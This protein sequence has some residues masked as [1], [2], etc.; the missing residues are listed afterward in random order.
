MSKLSK[1]ILNTTNEMLEFLVKLPSVPCGLP[2]EEKLADDLGV[3]R[4][5][6]RKVVDL[7]SEKGIVLKDGSNKM[8]LRRPVKND[9][10]TSKELDNS[11][12]DKIEKL[13][14]K[15]LSTY[16]LKPKDR[17]AE[18]ELAKAFDCNTVTVREVLL[19][20][21]QTG[22][23][24]K[25]P[26]QKWEVVSLTMDM[27]EEVVS[28]RKL[29]E[30]YALSKFQN[31]S[32]EDVIWQQLEKL[33]SN[34]LQILLEKN[35]SIHALAEIERAFHY[36]LL[37]ACGNRYIEKSYNSLF[38]LITYHLWQIEYD[39]TKIER[40]IKQHLEIINNLLNRQFDKAKALLQYHIEDAK[41]SMTDLVFS[42]NAH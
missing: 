26:R 17:F 30:G 19:K 25:S 32:D 16:E 20:I 2:P 13:I 22:I 38:T 39:H 37:R 1:L 6:I 14:L 28:A 34:H 42:K 7:L 11:K 24:K 15:K 23:I 10:Y 8:V 41:A 27:I 21:E 29:Y 36:T 4:T 5:T 12:A 35:R 9:F 3:S 40:V 31:M 33:K 18:L